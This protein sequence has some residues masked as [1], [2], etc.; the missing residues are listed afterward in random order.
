[1]ERNI[2]GYKL[3][4]VMTDAE[5]HEEMIKDIVGLADRFET[6]LDLNAQELSEAEDEL[7][8]E[9]EFDN[10]HF[11]IRPVE[12]LDPEVAEN[13]EEMDLEAVNLFF[14]D[15]EKVKLITEYLKKNFSIINVY[16]STEKRNY[17]LNGKKRDRKS[18]V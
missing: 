3:S 16:S 5:K 4:L 11:Y 15:N 14:G 10:F 6:V 7:G 1:M 9:F 2:N 17:K 12:Q 18:V 13:L 8:A